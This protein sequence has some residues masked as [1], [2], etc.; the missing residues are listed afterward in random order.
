MLQ[1]KNISFSYTKNPFINNLSFTIG[2]GELVSVLG[3][4]G[5]GKSTLLGIISGVIKPQSGTVLY[6]EKNIY[7]MPQRERAREIACIY[8]STDCAFPFTCYET[9]EMGLYPHKPKA[10]KADEKFILNVMRETETDMFADKLITEL[11]GGEIQR[12]LLA[13][14]LVQQPKLLLLDEAMSGFDIAVRLRMMSLLKKLARER[15][16]SII[17]IRH[18]IEAAFEDSDRI[19]AMKSGSLRYNGRPNTLMNKEFFKDI[20]NVDVTIENGHFHIINI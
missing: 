1:A 13:R 8:Q 20:F 15:K 9:A 10:D 12:V 6:N 19:V 7:S 17:L 5:S 2:E 11:S 4:N 3:A 14:A 16:M 18:D